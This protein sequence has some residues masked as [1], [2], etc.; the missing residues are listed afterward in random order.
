MNILL[1]NT[2]LLAFALW[3]CLPCVAQ[4]GRSR[5]DFAQSYIGLSSQI[6]PGFGS[7][8][9]LADES[10]PDSK[11]KKRLPTTYQP[12]L[13]IGGMHFWGHVDMMASIPLYGA[14]RSSV[15]GV[16]YEISTGFS[17][18]IRYYPLSVFQPTSFRLRPFGGVKWSDMHYRQKAAGQQKG[19]QWNKQILMLETGCA[20]ERKRY[21]A[22]FT[23]QWLPNHDYQYP[24]SRQQKGK[25]EFPFLSYHI[26]VKYLFDFTAINNQAEVQSA[27]AIWFQEL[28]Q[29]KKLNAFAIAIGISELLPVGH[30][31][32]K[33]R[34]DRQFLQNP[35][36]MSVFP[37]IALSQYFHRPD[38][39]IR[40]AFRPT[41]N[42]QEGYGFLHKSKRLSLSLE[43]YKFLFDYKGFV[44]FA[45]AGFGYNWLRLEEFDNGT[46]VQSAADS[47]FAPLFVIG[48]DIRP[49][50]AEWMLIRSNIRWTP[51][52]SMEVEGADL[53]YNDV[54]INFLQYV[55]FPGRFHLKFFGR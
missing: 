37:D 17:M 25:L 54:E 34:P 41:G 35:G 9:I 47:K 31:E 18:N 11:V 48:W 55:F 5:F 15:D 14:I 36:P 49:T 32:Y 6:L 7:T 40:L 52:L 10:D 51:W 30:S 19:I 24:I 38:A 13:D 12:R 1:K 45:G 28:E 43:A 27:N 50:R 16:S 29:K 3:L 4:E 42:K 8:Q 22:D 44:P 21:L 23:L 26:G 53:Q 39:E 46:Q 2:I 33:Q 20:F